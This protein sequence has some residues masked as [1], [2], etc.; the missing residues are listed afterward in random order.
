MKIQN[1][2]DGTNSSNKFKIEAGITP[3]EKAA[4][5]DY[6]NKET[7]NDNTIIEEY[8]LGEVGEYGK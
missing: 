3:E 2:F 6:K 7:T 8:K 5:K 4:Y 1:K